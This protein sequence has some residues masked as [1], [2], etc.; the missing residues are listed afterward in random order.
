MS[1]EVIVPVKFLFK[2]K[3]DNVPI[4]GLSSLHLTH[5]EHEAL[6]DDVVALNLLKEQGYNVIRMVHRDENIIAV[7]FKERF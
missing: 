3:P 1:Y 2:R 7:N 4:I 5:E 6:T